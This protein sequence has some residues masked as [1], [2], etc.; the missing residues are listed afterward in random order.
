[1]GKCWGWCG[2]VCWDV[3]KVGRDV[4][5]VPESVGRGLRKCVGVSGEVW[6]KCVRVWG[7]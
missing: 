6:E 5:E 2:K 4:G 7:R 3:E 1:M